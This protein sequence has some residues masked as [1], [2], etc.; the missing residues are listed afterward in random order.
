MTLKQLIDEALDSATAMVQAAELQKISDAVNKIPINDQ[1][2]DPTIKQQ[3]D[4][5]AKLVAAQLQQKKIQAA[6][7]QAQENAAKQTTTTTTNGTAQL[8]AVTQ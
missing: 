1:T 8:N 7:L 2:T 4:A 3:K 5:F 6:Q